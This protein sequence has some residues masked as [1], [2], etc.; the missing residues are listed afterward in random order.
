M[1]SKIRP[2][3]T[4]LWI[5][6]FAGTLDITD[7]LIFN[8][9]R[10]ITPKIVFQYIASGLIGL[11]A[12]RGGLA[13]VAL[14]VAIHYI[15][16]TY[17]DG[18]VL[19]GKPQACDSKPPA[20]SKRLSL[21]RR[22]IPVHEFHRPAALWSSASKERSH[23]CFE[24]QQCAGSSIL[25]WISHFTSGAAIFERTSSIEIVTASEP[26]AGCLSRESAGIDRAAR[27]LDSGRESAVAGVAGPRPPV[28]CCH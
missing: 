22:Y 14:G 19:C 13:S 24:G 12:F 4:I 18:C 26:M 25:Y 6:L 11:Q 8:Q 3:L 27:C 7:N 17:L 16:C 1:A 5:G 20:C 28:S 10:G 15:N 21:W 23:H 2:V 9:L